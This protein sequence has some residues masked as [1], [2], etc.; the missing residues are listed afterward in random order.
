M[1]DKEVRK[2]PKQ[3]NYNKRLLFNLLIKIYNFQQVLKF[4]IDINRFGTECIKKALR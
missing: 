3:F 2:V 1:K 4:T